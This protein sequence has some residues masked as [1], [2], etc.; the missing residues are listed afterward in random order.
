MAGTTAEGACPGGTEGFE[1]EKADIQGIVLAGFGDLG[2]AAYLLLR[3][4]PEG[5]ADRRR[6]AAA[7][8]AAAAEVTPASTRPRDEAVNLALTM[9]GLTAMG[10]PDSAGPF[11]PEFLGGMTEPFRSRALGDVAGNDPTLWEW[12]GREETTPHVLLL[13][14]ADT[15]ARLDAL[16]GR[17]RERWEAS[18]LA[19]ML[20][21]ERSTPG[22]KYEHFGFRDDVTTIP[23]EGGHLSSKRVG[24][25]PVKAGEF[26]L[27]YRNE[28]GRCPATPSLTAGGGGPARDLGRNGTFLVF[29]KLREDAPA[30]WR[31]CRQQAERTAATV[32]GGCGA[33]Y[34]AAKMM[35][36]WREGAPLV[37]HPFAPPP[38]DTPRDRFDD[39]QYAEADRNG[40]RCPVGSH[41]RRSNPRD[42]LQ[43]L[44]AASAE[45][46]VNRHRIARRGRPYG[47]ERADPASEADDGKERGI[48]FL[49]VNADIARQFEFVQQTWLN[50]PKFGR[51]WNEPDPV[52]GSIDNIQ[53]KDEPPSQPDFTIPQMPLRV[54]LRDVPR[55]VA[56]RAGAYFF[57]PGLSTLRFLAA[58]ARP[59]RTDT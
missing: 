49:C 30:F 40:L 43:D 27:G 11:P 42:A 41:I 1:L 8:E 24:R 59:P 4:T 35:G 26:V 58:L 51:L 5:I 17:Q 48:L 33:E 32:P 57:V 44:D 12:G 55:F 20:A 47:E 54:R 31:Y 9:P 14:Y 34:I 21:E 23:I 45:R 50:D 13:C 56:V 53:T 18:G 46:I 10:L 2:H 16:V 3:F 28:Y 15:A 39:F 36:R 22:L 7:L 37:D 19:V 29:R 52:T 6:L 38:P 25:P